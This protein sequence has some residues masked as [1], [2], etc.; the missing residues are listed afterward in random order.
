MIQKRDSNTKGIYRI[1]VRSRLTQRW[2]DWFDG[3]Q[4][5]YLDDDTLL[6]GTVED[7]AALHG[8]LA[9][10]RDLGLPILLVVN[11]EREHGEDDRL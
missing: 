9:K 7:Q 6:T 3:F 11:L 8:I 5:R 1:Q 2:S 10:I 4:M